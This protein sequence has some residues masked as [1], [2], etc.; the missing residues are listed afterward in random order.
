MKTH[1]QIYILFLMVV[2][3]NAY[4][5]NPTEAKK[6]MVNSETQNAVSSSGPNK[7]VRN[8]IQDSKG[9]IWLASAEG[10]I[11]YDGKSFT[12][13]TAKVIPARFSAVLEDGK[14]NFWFATTG[15]GVYYYN[16]VSFSNFTTRQGLANDR[17]TSIYEDKN[18]NVWFGTQNGASRYDGRSFTNLRMKETAP[19]PPGNNDSTRTVAEIDWKQNDVNTI[20]ED[21]TGKFWFGT[22]KDASVYDGKTFATIS[23]KDG[24]ALTNIRSMIKDKKGNIWLGGNDGLWCYNGSTFINFT[25]N[26]VGYIYEDKNGNIWTSSE[27]SGSRGWVISRYDAKTL[28]NKKPAV[29]EIKPENNKEIFSMLEAADGSIWF[30]SVNGVYRYDGKTFTDFK[31]KD[32][33]SNK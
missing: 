19:P 13:I 14:G 7:T 27:S 20:V 18:D 4:G 10:I 3:N 30:G 26:V 25:S 31:N 9:N 21:K 24:K 23:D 28:F 32:T 12:N 17:V 6:I 16:G 29:T 8:L 22:Q 2:L 11:R 1:T 15:S 33:N 5:Q